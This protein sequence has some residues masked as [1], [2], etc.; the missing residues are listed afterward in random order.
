M[1]QLSRKVRQL[2]SIGKPPA[3][4]EEAILDTAI[5]FMNAEVCFYDSAEGPDGPYDPI[6]GVGGMVIRV[7]WRGKARVQQLRSPREFETEYQA[8]ANRSFRFQLDPRDSVPDLYQGVKARVLA[9]G[10]DPGLES[11]AYVVNSAINSSHKAVRTV[12]L[13]ATMRKTPWDWNPSPVAPLIFP[14]FDRFPD[15]DLFPT[16]V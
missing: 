2:V 6:T 5:Q 10:R 9:G 11:L 1:G 4:W 16:G 12:E 15:T 14:A 3:N 7:L 8:S 13:T